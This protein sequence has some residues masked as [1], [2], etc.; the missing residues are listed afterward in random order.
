M[1]SVQ[2][3]DWLHPYQNKIYD[4][5]MKFAGKLIHGW[6]GHCC[7]ASTFSLMNKTV[8]KGEGGQRA[9]KNVGFWS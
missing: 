2:A 8:V 4:V 6:P 3:W 5:P 9:K 1:K 7:R